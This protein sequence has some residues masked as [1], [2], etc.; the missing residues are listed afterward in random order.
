ME[1]RQNHTDGHRNV[2]ARKWAKYHDG[3]ER[4]AWNGDFWECDNRIQNLA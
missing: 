1:A 3:N 2:L 4:G